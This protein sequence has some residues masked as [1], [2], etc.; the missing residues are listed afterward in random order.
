[1]AFFFPQSQCVVKWSFAHPEDPCIRQ[2]SSCAAGLSFSLWVKVRFHE[3][4]LNVHKVHD[5]K[6]IFST[7]QFNKQTNKQKIAICNPPKKIPK[8]SIVTQR[9]PASFLPVQVMMI[10]TCSL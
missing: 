9:G 4:V 7:G 8:I 5:R 2:M 3:D 10:I 6:Y 1:M